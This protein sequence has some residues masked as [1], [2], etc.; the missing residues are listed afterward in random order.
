MNDFEVDHGT[1]EVPRLPG[2]LFRPL[3]LRK[4]GNRQPD[5]HTLRVVRPPRGL[6]CQP[7]GN[8]GMDSI[9]IQVCVTEN[10]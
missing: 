8:T 2:A 10:S 4:G 9:Y 5:G 6:L 1:P 7:R 3:P